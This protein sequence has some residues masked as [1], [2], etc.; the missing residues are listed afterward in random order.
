MAHELIGALSPC[1][2]RIIFAGSLR[3]KK[4]DVGDVEILY[5]PKQ[6]LADVGELFETPKNLADVAIE[7]LLRQF[8]LRKRKNVNGYETFGPKNKLLR[9]VLSGI[10]VDLFAAT[11]ENWWNYFVCRTGGAGS[12]VLIAERAKARGYKWNPYGCG[13][14]RLADGEAIPMDSEEA[15]FRFVGLRCEEPWLRR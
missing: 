3:R 10:P 12:N 7:A 1:T 6:G 8:V 5:I 14:T 11:P 15:V 4:P 13:F 9:H 2:E